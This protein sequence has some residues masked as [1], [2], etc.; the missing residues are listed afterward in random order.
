[1]KTDKTYD[2]ADKALFTIYPL[3]PISNQQR[4]TN[5]DNAGSMSTMATKIDLFNS[6]NLRWD[7]L[8]KRKSEEL[9]HFL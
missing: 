8:R 5:K 9:P 1:V 7:F 6:H 2:S 4:I 3:F